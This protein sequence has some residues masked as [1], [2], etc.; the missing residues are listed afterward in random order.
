MM[1]EDCVTDILR[2]AVRVGLE[3]KSLEVQVMYRAPCQFDMLYVISQLGPL[4]AR[5][6]DTAVRVAGERLSL[7]LES[8]WIEGK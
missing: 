1:I 6:F 5:D 7:G 3:S 8:T 2:H 4:L